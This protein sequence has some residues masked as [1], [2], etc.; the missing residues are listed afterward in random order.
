MKRY[1]RI[2]LCIFLIFSSVLVFSASGYAIKSME[3][4]V[5]ITPE[6]VYEVQE[7]IIMDFL[8]PLHGFYRTLPVEY[9]FQD[10]DREDVRV[11]VSKIKA[12]DTLKV[13]REGSYVTIRLGD[14]DRTV[15]GLQDYSISYRYDIGAD[16]Y[17]DYDEFYFNIVGEEWEVPIE[18]F[19]F[20]IN[21]PKPVDASSISFSRGVWG[22]RTSVG[23]Q[24]QLASDGLSLSGQSTRLEPGEAITVRVQM[25]EGYFEERTNWQALYRVI[26]IVLS[27]LAV[28]LAWY[29]WSTHG[30]DKDLIIV[31]R[32]TP[33]EGMSPLDYGYIIDESL[34]PHDVTSMIFYWA[35]K[36]CLTIV[37][38]GKKFSFIRGRDPQNV[39]KHEQQLFDAFFASGSNGVV[40]SSDLEGDFFKSYVKLQSTVASHYSGERALTSKKSRNFATLTILLMLIPAIGYA[41]SLTGNYAGPE[42][43]VLGVVSLFSAV[44]LVVVFH[45]MLRIWHIRKT[46]GK[47][48]WIILSLVTIVAGWV[49]LVFGAFV[50]GAVVSESLLMATIGMSANAILAFFAIITKQRSEYGRRCLEEVLGFRDFI[51]NVELDQLKRMIE[52][53]PE[54]YYRNLAFAIV[55]GLEKDWAKKFSSITLEPP[56]WYVGGSYTVWNAMALSSMMNRCNAALAPAITT[57][58][59]SSPGSRFGGSSSGGGGFSGGG[60]GG[61]GGGAW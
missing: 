41:L 9:L 2:A 7:K 27:F 23:V 29:F 21:F 34:D 24:W 39:S 15:T 20:T 55:L 40:K 16:P 28:I 32:F 50:V 22:T 61:G 5:S 1:R 11:R 60:F 45:G 49:I 44:L 33:S 3:S 37:E 25:P 52:D 46:F 59:K 57:A 35:D 48:L 12:S 54:Y 47:F 13:M 53:D 19:F 58:P 4:E 8:E 51:K 6:G 14:A 30:R 31:P 17:P 10:I 42:T 36:G 26:F 38:E 56:T 18:K 43:L